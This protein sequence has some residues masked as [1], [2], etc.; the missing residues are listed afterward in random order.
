MKAHKDFPLVYLE[1]T[2]GHFKGQIQR[3]NYGT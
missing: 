3:E 1:L 2:L